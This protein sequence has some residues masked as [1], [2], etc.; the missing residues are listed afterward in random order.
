MGIDFLVTV[1]GGHKELLGF[2][3]QGRG[4]RPIMQKG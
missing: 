4:L 2:G 1:T 3:E